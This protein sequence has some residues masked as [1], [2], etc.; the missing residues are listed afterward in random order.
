MLSLAPPPSPPLSLSLPPSP[1]LP[2]THMQC[3]VYAGLCRQR[4]VS[5]HILDIN[6]T[7]VVALYQY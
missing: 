1:S 4:L 6:S 7:E 3:L 5:Q 2:P